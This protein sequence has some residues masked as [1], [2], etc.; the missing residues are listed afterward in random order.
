M[1][2]QRLVRAYDHTLTK[3][4]LYEVLLRC[5]ALVLCI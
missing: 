5:N 4:L 3:P 1:Q 2:K